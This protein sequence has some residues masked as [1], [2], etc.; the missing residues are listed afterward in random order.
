MKP[1]QFIWETVRREIRAAKPD[2]NYQYVNYHAQQAYLKRI[3][4][5]YDNLVA[6]LLESKEFDVNEFNA[7]LGI[8]NDRISKADQD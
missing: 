6:Q 3:S 5:E 4:A 2:A 1:S 8:E 7:E